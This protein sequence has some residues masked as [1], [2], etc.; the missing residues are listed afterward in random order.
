MV[1]SLFISLFSFHIILHLIALIV[2]MTPQYIEAL[3]YVRGLLVVIHVLHTYYMMIISL[4]VQMTP[5]YIKAVVL[6]V[7]HENFVY[8]F[9]K[10]CINQWLESPGGVG[11]TCPMC[12]NYIVKEDEFP[13]LGAVRKF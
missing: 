10:V 12:R 11:S 13:E 4:I 6:H 7:L 8:R 2:Q 1:S 3:V 9:H 5:Q